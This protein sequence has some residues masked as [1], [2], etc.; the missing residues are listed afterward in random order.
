MRFS[1]PS[2]R[3]PSSRVNLGEQIHVCPRHEIP[4]ASPDRGA[5]VGLGARVYLVDDDELAVWNIKRLLRDLRLHIMAYSSAQAFLDQYEPAECECLI[6]GQGAAL[7]DL[8]RPGHSRERPAAPP[9]IFV[10]TDADVD[11]VVQAMRQG[12]FDFLSKPLDA[13]RLSRAVYGALEFSQQ[14][15]LRRSRIAKEKA[16]E[17]LLTPRE[18]SIVRGVV[19]GYSSKEIAQHLQLS[20]RTVENRKANIYTK[21]NVR[22]SVG[23][24]RLFM[25]MMQSDQEQKG[26]ATGI[27]E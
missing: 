23:L 27:G 4:P 9:T 2:Q 12:A 6:V 1:R 26:I 3:P 15:H 13:E 7:H 11:D 25:G 14:D 24:A 10:T 18:L 16:R 21:L 20:V 17:A 8:A 5:G 22:S 19:S